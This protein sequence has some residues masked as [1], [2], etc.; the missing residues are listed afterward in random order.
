M[1]MLCIIWSGLIGLISSMAARVK[2]LVFVGNFLNRI[3]RGTTTG[4]GDA[5]RDVVRDLRKIEEESSVLTLKDWRGNDVRIPR[6][7]I[8]TT[9]VNPFFCIHGG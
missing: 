9:I 6:G 7:R 1:G 8:S 5:V 2:T 3:T 4:R